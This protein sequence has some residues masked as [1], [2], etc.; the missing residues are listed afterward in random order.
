MSRDNVEVVRSVH[1]NG[2]DMVSFIRDAIAAD[3]APDA[4]YTEAF[5]IDFVTEFISTQAGLLRPAARG[6]VGFAEGWRDWLEP[7][8][9][10]YMEVEE[11]L[12]AGEL[13]VSLV[14]VRA[15]TER[16]G[17]AIEHS[18]ASVWSLHGGKITRVQFYLERERALEA[19][20]LAER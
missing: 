6:I 2:I 17:V 7:W 1:P 5:E 10:Y 3:T 4:V 12:D 18:P 11:L 9:S 19:A 15:K 8:D 14:R 16:D 13:V 20:G